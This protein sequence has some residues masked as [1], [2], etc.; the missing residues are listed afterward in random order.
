MI[1]AIILIFILFLIT[2]PL[3]SSLE[4]RYK[5]FDAGFMSGLYWYH[6]LFAAIYYIYVQSSRSDSIGYYERAKLAFENWSQA[7]GTG[8]TFIDWT[9]YPFIQYFGFSYEMMMVLF[10]Y[11]G[12]LGFVAFYIV[13]K[14][15]IR[16]KH[17]FYGID[18]ITLIFFLPNM[19][20]WTASLGKGSLIFFG[21]GLTTYGLSKLK[22]R[23]F[24]LSLGLLLIYHI[25]PHVFFLM[26]VAIVLGMMTGRHKVPLY[27]K[28]L[29]LAGGAVAIALLYDDVLS[30]A[31]LDSDNLMG[32]F[33]ALSQHRAYELS[34][35]GSG[36]DISNY[37]LIF[38]LFTFWFRP[39]FVDA[40]G[41]IGIVVSFENLICLVLAAKLI[42][43]RFLVFLAK[44]SALVKCSGIVFLGI[45][46]AL[47]GTLSNLGIIIRQKSMVMYFFLFIIV[48]FLDYLKASENPAKKTVL[49]PLKQKAPVRRQLQH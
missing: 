39:L 13:F 32:S 5:K 37:P 23:I 21:L 14:E 25:R 36:L 47:S 22:S 24:L 38:K 9:A 4:S 28:I 12:Y 18:L 10:S 20:Y 7:Y 43:G 41:P 29:V 27:Q 33:E 2:Q 26:A 45:S 15:N 8:T 16:F 19:H 42:S 11:L 17:N 44:S 34:K 46:F 35:S 6:V 30:F 48:S 49:R 3:L 31:S 40:P 1:G